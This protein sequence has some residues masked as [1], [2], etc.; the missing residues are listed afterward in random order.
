VVESDVPKEAIICWGV[1]GLSKKV[2]QI[3]EYGIW[4]KWYFN[5][6]SVSKKKIKANLTVSHNS[7]EAFLK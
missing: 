7:N 6:S 1:W 3:K 2:F 4:E 5:C